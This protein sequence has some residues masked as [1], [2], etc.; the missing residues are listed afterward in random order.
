MNSNKINYVDVCCGLA[1]GDEAKGKIVS[2]LAKSGKYEYVCRWAGGDNAGHTIYK[3]G[4]KYATHLIPSGIF[5]G[6]KSIIGPGCVVNYKSF[7]KE[8]QYMKENGFDTS[9]IKI[10]NKT[11][12]ILDEHIEEDISHSKKLGTTSRGIGPC[13][14][15]KYNRNGTR[16][17]DFPELFKDYIWDNVLYGN[18]LCEGA[19][20]VWLDIDYGNYPYVTSSNTLPYAACS[21]GFS[22][23]YI[24][25]IYGA[26]KI[27]DTRSGVDPDF[28][29]ELFKNKELE[30]I[31]I[32]GE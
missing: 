12:V 11:H 26:A 1:W 22:P 14:R 20:G 18:I 16:V 24:R 13:Y 10:S 30:L 7:M 28:P 15:D 4:K 2:Y 19:Q 9:L 27:Y 8:I 29:E 21:L 6:I 31:G 23:K 25:H 5:Y 3:D 32:Y 17:S